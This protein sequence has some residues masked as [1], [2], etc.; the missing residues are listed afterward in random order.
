MNRRSYVAQLLATIR[1]YGLDRWG[2]VEQTAFMAEQGMLSEGMAK[3]ELFRIEP[4]IEQQKRCP[5]R[6]KKPPEPAELGSYDVELGELVEQPGVRVGLR[7]SD[8][9]RHLLVAGAT[10]AGKSVNLR[11]TIAG[12]DAHGRS[13]GCPRTILVLD[14]KGDFVDIPQRLGRDRWDHYSIH[15]GFRLGLNSPANLVPPNVWV[16]QVTKVI[17]TRCDLIMS[18]SSLSAM[19]RFALR[20][21][22]LSPS[23][24]VAWPSIPLLYDIIC[25][26]KF[27]AFAA[28]G[29]YGRS[30]LQRLAELVSNAS[31]IF[32]TLRGFD[33]VEHL[34]SPGRNAVIDLT[35]LEPRIANIVVDLIVSQ[36]LY[37]RLYQRHTV[38][39]T[40]V[41]LIIDEADQFCSVRSSSAYPE[42]FS[43]LAQIMKQG[44]E[45]G[46]MVCLGMT[47]LGFCSRFIS[48]NATYHF[49]FAQQDPDSIQEA[50]HTLQ[51][52][53]GQTMMAS[54]P[55]G[56]C[57]YKEAQGPFPHGMLMQADFVEP[58]RTGRP[59]RFDQHPHLPGKRIEDLPELKEAVQQL[60][61]QHRTQAKTKSEGLSED[62][63]D[64]L[65]AACDHPWY[66]VARLWEKVG[67]KPSPE[68]QKKARIA[69]QNKGLAEFDQIRVG[70]RNCLMIIPTREGFGALQLQPRSY[71]G[72]G[73]IAHNH[74]CHWLSIWGERQCFK[75]E[76]EALVPGTN[77]AADCLWSKDG[78]LHAFEVV[79]TCEGNVLSHLNACFIQSTAV[80]TVTLVA[81]QK[82]ILDDLRRIVTSE[83]AMAPYLDR[84]RWL[85]AEDIVRELW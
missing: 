46:I 31:D 82:S 12:L 26:T 75:V 66:P 63:H 3:A 67:R 15:D 49:L 2:D 77:H 74:V 5:N 42:G 64:L 71:H 14:M 55:T 84:V 69:L 24:P 44:R 8:R 11:R 57:I 38:D 34:T 17:G 32:S 35:T 16:N 6:L 1:E 51:L 72:R 70:K 36:L 45:F 60:N 61:A 28:K 48:A 83:R 37:S 30:A 18:Q 22:N 33:V 21:L 81:F 40:E 54:L 39:T 58:A 41:V 68:A 56:T 65:H 59:A 80:T 76:I 20:V 4:R 19:M 13:H 85:S 53:G 9:P 29:D 43:P 10:G 7:V 23:P 47:F 62:A 25:K 52:P 79:A 27:S 50:V 73:G 78:I